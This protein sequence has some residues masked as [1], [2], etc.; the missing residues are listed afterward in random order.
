M[1]KHGYDND[2]GSVTQILGVLRKIGLEWWFKIN[3]PKSCDEESSK[4]KEIGT[5]IHEVIQAHI[6]KDMLTIET[7]YEEEVSNALKSFML[8]RKEH[9]EIKLHKSEMPLTSKKYEYNGTLDCKGNDGVEVIL[10]WKTGKCKKKSKPP[11]YDEYLYQVSA[12]VSAYNE[13]EKANIERAYILSIAKDRI[14][15]NLKL[16]ETKQLKECFNEVF[17]SALKIF[18]Y[19]KRK[20]NAR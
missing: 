1:S 11:I 13:Q 6:E 2:Y 14:A 7:K 18:N 9:P 12:Y 3:T 15:Y 5:K 16:L 20:N 17:L 8:F 10:D 19:Q 4:S